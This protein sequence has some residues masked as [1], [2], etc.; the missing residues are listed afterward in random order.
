MDFPPEWQSSAL[1]PSES[2][3]HHEQ[4]RTIAVHSVAV[5]PT[6][7]RR[8][9]GKTLIKSYTQRMESSGIADRV[10][11]LAHDHFVKFYEGVGFSN[12]GP[13]DCKSY[14]GSW[15]NMVRKFS[16]P[17]WPLCVENFISQ[18]ANPEP[19]MSRFMNSPSTV[20]VFER[21]PVVLYIP[22]HQQRLFSTPIFCDLLYIHRGFWG[23]NPMLENPLPSLNPPQNIQ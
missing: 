2:R 12:R 3:G 6:Y 1:S 15:F 17:S 23:E 4:G 19:E 22:S 16:W 18:K 14:G 5:L 20:R 10:S 11:L 9:L 8:G 13:S 7:H 21:N